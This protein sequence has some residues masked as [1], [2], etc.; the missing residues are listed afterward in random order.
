[1]SF[2][3]DYGKKLGVFT[4][5]GTWDAS[6][7]TP[8][9]TGGVGNK[10]E[11]YIVSVT[12]TT[13]LDGETGWEIGDWIYFNGSTW[14]RI[15][16][17][18]SERLIINEHTAAFYESKEP[19]GHADSTKSILSF[20]ESTRTL[21]ISPV[22]SSFDIWIRGKKITISSTL[23]KQIPNTSGSY[24]FTID[25][26][27]VLD[28]QQTFSVSILT[29]KA[30]TAYVYWNA[31]DEKAISFGEERHGISMDGTTHGYLHS[32][33][34]TQLVSG[35][36]IGYVTTGSGSSNMDAQI[37]ISD[38]QLRD[39]DI[40]ADIR[41]SNSPSAQFEQILSPIAE[42]PTYYRSGSYWSKATATQ[43][44]LKQGISRAQYNKN[45]AGVWSL[46]DASVDG[47]F[48]VSYIF[49]TTNVSQP[50]IALLGQDE[51]TSVEDAKA[52]AAWSAVSFGD[53]PAQEMKLLYIVIYETSSAFTNTP[54]AVIKS[55]VDLRFGA[56][57][58][59]SATSFNTAHSNLSGLGLDDH[60]Q[61]FNQERGDARYYTKQSAD[62]LFTLQSTF[63]ENAQD[64][65]GNSLLNTA[66]VEF[67]YNDLSN[68]ISANVPDAS[69]T[70]NK[71]ASG[72]D[73]AKI[74]GGQV[75]NTEFSY[76]DGVTSSIQTQL[77]AKEPSI[78]TG[79][80]SQYFRGDKTFQTLN[81]TV[82]ANTPTGNI[83]STTVQAAIN[84]LDTEKQP[85]GNYI[86]ALTGDVSASGPNSAV[87]TLST[88]GVAAGTY[89]SVTVDTKG[90]V[91][92]GTTTG[93]VSRYTATN[94]SAST[95][96]TIT[97]ST[98]T[99]LTTA[100]LPVGLYFFKFAGLM[101]ST[102][103]TSGVGVRL[104]P[105]TATITTISGKWNLSQGADGVSHDF[106]YDQITTAA[107]VTSSS[108]NT[109]NT[110]FSVNGF[111]IFRVTVAGT[112]SIQIRSETAGQTATLQPDAVLVVE[113][114]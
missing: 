93:P 4:Y 102:Q 94:S 95:N 38:L 48:L 26:N 92:N 73:A 13:D 2:T 51:Y 98:A 24:F 112:V 85:V 61:Y 82:V 109:A 50:V 17:A 74:D 53:L 99:G 58:E 88:T 47:K 41:H 71:I 59:V 79:T 66:T 52:R 97:Y 3:L 89:T 42:I 68:T 1:M 6:T 86:T 39:E 33:R 110:N 12:G 22:T 75:S 111:G 14:E 43:Y 29:E 60:L 32:T 16:T 20:N 96:A 105:G 44:P 31:A 87:A 27:G 54:K 46:Q 9:L 72:I 83:S 8:T 101:Q 15:N 55:V 63:N 5:K 70:N 37:S 34:G 23:S 104:F 40:R 81:G 35:A 30:Y 91:T 80:T 107:N 57:R 113:L 21:S 84:E 90:R 18:D 106:E 11:Y 10:N 100:S 36:S 103:A 7:N 78:I 114:V 64:A 67:T 65:V 19:T 45:T 69:I 25:G 28:Y 62:S 56:D 49:G 76:L 108:V 77:D